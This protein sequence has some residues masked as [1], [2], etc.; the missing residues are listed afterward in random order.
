M[1]NPR[2]RYANPHS[3]EG[4]IAYE[5]AAEA[6]KEDS[7][8]NFNLKFK[9]GFDF[10]Q[11]AFEGEKTEKLENAVKGIISQFG[12]PAEENIYVWEILNI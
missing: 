6:I 11:F 1:I 4:I 7:N 5:E 12:T 10:I 9:V 3:E 8:R 2:F